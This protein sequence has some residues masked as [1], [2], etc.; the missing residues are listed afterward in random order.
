MSH[1]AVLGFLDDGDAGLHEFIANV[2]I[3][4]QKAMTAFLNA[5]RSELRLPFGLVR[6]PKL[7]RK[8]F[9][10][11]W[12]YQ[13]RFNTDQAVREGTLNQQT[14]DMLGRGYFGVTRRPFAVRM[15]EHHTEMKSG[16]GHLLHAVWRDLSERNIPHRVIAQ[17][18]QHSGSEDEIYRLEEQVVDEYTLAPKGLN[19]IPGGRSGVAHLRSLGFHAAGFENRDTVTCPGDYPTTS[20]EVSLQERSP[21]RV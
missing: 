8:P 16:G 11:C 9:G 21:A 7:V 15:T 13:I 18:V 12:L 14:F 19:M 5:A 17:L 1:I 2:R 20:C 4:Y 10:N 6:D 3:D